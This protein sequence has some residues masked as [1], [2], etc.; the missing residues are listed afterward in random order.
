VTVGAGWKVSQTYCHSEAAKGN[1]RAA[2]APIT[3]IS[4]G[5][6]IL[7]FQLTLR[8]RLRHGQINCPLNMWTY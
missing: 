1:A 8:A 2:T 5:T 7:V 6:I 3:A 4:M